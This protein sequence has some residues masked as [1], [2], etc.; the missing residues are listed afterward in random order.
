[1]K[2]MIEGEFEFELSDVDL[3]YGRNHI[4]VMD[5]ITAVIHWTYEH[6]KIWWEM[7]DAKTGSE[8]DITVSNFGVAYLIM[9]ESIKAELARPKINQQLIAVIGEA[10]A[11]DGSATNEDDEHR[12]GQNQLI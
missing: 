12:L 6:G 4:G 1:M 11:S 3:M 5:E 9:V 8:V 7:T 10:I 2:S